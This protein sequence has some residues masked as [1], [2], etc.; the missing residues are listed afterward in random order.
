WARGQCGLPLAAKNCSTTL[1]IVS[2]Q[3]YV[4]VS[5]KPANS[6]RMISAPISP[7]SVASHPIDLLSSLHGRQAKPARCKSSHE[8]W[9]LPYTNFISWDLTSTESD[10]LTVSLPFLQLR[11]TI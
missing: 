10:L 11:M 9:K 4:W 2:G 3:M 7:K 5:L 8:A 6:R 1:A